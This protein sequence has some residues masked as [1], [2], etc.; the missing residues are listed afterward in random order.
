[1]LYLI[2]YNIL[3]HIMIYYI[4]Q[5]IMIILLLQHDP[6][7]PVSD[8]R[9]QPHNIISNVVS[10]NIQYFITYNNILYTTKHYDNIIIAA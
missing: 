2:I 10:Y 6:A 1:M 4:L 5:N 8:N 9:H 3:L 7:L